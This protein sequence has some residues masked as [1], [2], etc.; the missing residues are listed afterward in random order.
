MKLVPAVE[1]DEHWPRVKAGLERIKAKHPVS[2]IPE[3][4]Y[5]A[6]AQQEAWLALVDGGFIVFQVLP[7]DDKRGLMH[8]WALEGKGYEHAAKEYAE[9]EA[10]CREK[11]IRTIRQF[12]RKGWGKDPFWRMTGYVYEHTVEPS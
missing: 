7:G 3:H 11:G 1:L 10:W 12:G 5:R 4:V 6:I 8:I 9:L 2:W